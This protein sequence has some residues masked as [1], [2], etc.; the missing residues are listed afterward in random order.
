MIN[1]GWQKYTTVKTKV[2]HNIEGNKKLRNNK[3]IKV[4]NEDAKLKKI[5]PLYLVP[6]YIRCL[7]LQ[8]PSSPSAEIFIWVITFLFYTSFQI[9]YISISMKAV[10]LIGIWNL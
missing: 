5:R 8:C 1:L 7:Y 4:L 9:I 10:D 2:G 6:F 3:F